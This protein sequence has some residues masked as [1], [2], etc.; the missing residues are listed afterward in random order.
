MKVLVAFLFVCVLAVNA[1]LGMIPEIVDI[2]GEIEE[3]D[4]VLGDER[5]IQSSSVTG[6]VESYVTFP[7]NVSLKYHEV[8]T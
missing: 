7:M 8:Q 6:V 2:F 1:K 5:I 4:V 3:Y